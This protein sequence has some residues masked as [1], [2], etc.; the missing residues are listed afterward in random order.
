[1][2]TAVYSS[3]VHNHPKLEATQMFF[4]GVVD[5]QICPYNRI[6]HNNKEQNNYKYTQHKQTLDTMEQV[7]TGTYKG[8]HI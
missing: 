4:S 8:L 5:K 1:M 2:F 7:K 3:V 6:L